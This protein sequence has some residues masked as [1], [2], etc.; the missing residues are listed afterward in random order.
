M[1][2]RY[3][4]GGTNTWNN[5]AGTKWALTDGGAGG[6]A[7][8]TSADNVY[9]TA[10]SG[11]VTVTVTI[12]ANLFNL[13]C[14]GFTG[15]LNHTGGTFRIYG[16]IFK[17][18]V[19]M[20]ITG[21]SGAGYWY[22]FTTGNL[23]WTSAGKTLAGFYIVMQGGVLDLQDD[24]VITNTLP[25]GGLQINGD[26]SGLIT[27]NHNVTVN[28]LIVSGGYTG[29]S[30]SLGS[31]LIT[32]TGTGYSFF[33]P[34][35][36]CSVSAGTSTLKFTGNDYFGS[37]P[38]FD[39]GGKTYYNIWNAT[40]STSSLYVS[41]NSDNNTFNNFKVSANS[42]TTVYGGKTII[43]SS[44]TSLGTA[45]NLAILT[46][47]NT[48]LWTISSSSK[49]TVDYINLSYSTGYPNNTFY[50]GINSTDSGNNSGWVFPF[51]NP[52][53][54]YTQDGNYTTAASSSATLN[55]EISKDG[56]TTW[57]TP[58]S[59]TFTGSD[60]TLTFGSGSTELWGN[61][62]TRADVVNANL[63]LRL[64]SGI[65]GQIYK[66]FGFSTGS[67]ILTGLEVAVRGKYSAPTLS[68]DV[69]E[70]KIYYG[71]STLLIQAGSQAF[72]SNGRKN[73]EGAGAGTGVL[74]FFDG[75]A[76][77]ACDTGATVAA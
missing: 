15:T 76:W 35:V 64:S 75:T 73:G 17:L 43:V 47:T 37:R 51:T 56:G 66:T 9:F 6:Q 63:R 1:A 12:N 39:G 14:T 41:Q 40:P 71:S 49:I 36:G 59:K 68:M 44:L 28:Q 34:S 13:D 4:V 21:P 62:W 50:A 29:Q 25:A 20:T 53:N 42:T 61:S 48:S 77:K 8:P 10:T 60:S 52:T 74:V 30:I 54:I 5:T 27:N 70:M 57:S 55:I 23:A 2:N 32:L 7:V 65:Y 33:V 11:A 24:L 46:S 31:S 45:G 26:N 58:L 72:A 69:L 16:N 19:G 67:D 3:W 18:S 38:S 22:T